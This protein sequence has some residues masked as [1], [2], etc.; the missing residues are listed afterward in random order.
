M[1]EKGFLRPVKHIEDGEDESEAHHPNGARRTASDSSEFMR[2]S[3]PGGLPRAEN[4]HNPPPRMQE[5]VRDAKERHFDEARKAY[6]DASRVMRH[7][8]DNYHPQLERFLADEK[9][10]NIVGTRTEF[11]GA[12]FLEHAEATHE[13][14]IAKARYQFAK[15]EAKRTGVIPREVW[16]SDFGDWPDDGYEERSEKGSEDDL[17]WGLTKERIEKWRADEGQ[18]DLLGQSEWE[19]HQ[20]RDEDGHQSIAASSHAAFED[21]AEGKMRRL[22]DEVKAHQERLRA[23]PAFVALRSNM[24]EA[25]REPCNRQW[26][27]EICGIY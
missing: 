21:V 27:Q 25:H 9:K 7:I 3:Q 19:G 22:I 13:L 11:D 14:E 10:G 26:F 1:V 2:S 23:A 17:V 4:T 15:R 12:C 20:L 18:K 8:R 16:T 5:I 24:M 6:S